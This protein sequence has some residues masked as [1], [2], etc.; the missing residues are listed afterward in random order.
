PAAR[1]LTAVAADDPALAAMAGGAGTALGTGGMATKV[2]AA[3]R[4]SGS[5]ADTLI[6]S[7]REPD[8]LPRLAGGEAIGPQLLAGTARLAARKQWLAGQLQ[9]A[10]SLTLDAGAVRAVVHGG[11]SLLPIGVVAVRGDFGRGDVVAC[12]D[13]E[14][15]EIARGLANYS[16][17]QTR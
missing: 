1:L 5:G 12:L 6:A 17:T 14:G 10:G 9:L 15:R 3:R 7:G 11:R 2:A 4:A 8:L 16:A 13:T